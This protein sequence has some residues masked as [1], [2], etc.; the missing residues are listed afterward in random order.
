MQDLALSK[1]ILNSE[2]IKN[3][4][5]RISKFI[6][7]EN[8]SGISPLFSLL[9]CI[10]INIIEKSNNNDDYSWNINDAILSIYLYK[11]ETNYCFLYPDTKLNNIPELSLPDEKLIIDDTSPLAIENDNIAINLEDDSENIK[12][13]D[14]YLENISESDILKEKL[15]GFKLKSALRRKNKLDEERKARL[16][17]IDP[18][19]DQRNDIEKFADKVII[20]MQTKF[21]RIT[22]EKIECCYEEED[23]VQD[24]NLETPA[25]CGSYACRECIKKLNKTSHFLFNSFC[26]NQN[27]FKIQT[28]VILEDSKQRPPNKECILCGKEGSRKS[29]ISCVCCFLNVNIF[30]TKEF[31]SSAGC[32]IMKLNNWINI[33]EDTS[34]ELVKC[35]F[36]DQKRNKNYVFLTCNKCEDKICL[37]CLRRNPYIYESSCSECYERREIY[38]M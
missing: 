21:S 4:L 22:V 27:L 31:K 15:K 35:N 12:L 7:N 36:C 8:E 23:I 11:N 18:E 9:K 32:R 5:E 17:N 25:F 16:E 34:N 14:E 38:N 30:K 26:C 3:L 19:N 33:D 37:C 13:G 28:D 24:N 2:K 29:K 20:A 1:Q 10:K 6:P